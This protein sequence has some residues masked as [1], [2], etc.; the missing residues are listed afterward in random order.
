MLVVTAENVAGHR[1]VEVKG[2][3]F[4]VVVRSRGLGGNVMAGLRSLVG[5]ARRSGG[6][7]NRFAG[8]GSPYLFP[9]PRQLAAGHSR[10]FLQLSGKRP[11]DR[12]TRRGDEGALSEDLSLLRISLMA[13]KKPVPASEKRPHSL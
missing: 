5:T 8:G 6:P 4:G 9:A 3:C 7:N 12:R 11:R 10:V 13:G 1:V 2:Q